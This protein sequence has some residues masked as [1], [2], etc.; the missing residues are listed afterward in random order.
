MKIAKDDSRLPRVRRSALDT[1]IEF[2]KQDLDTTDLR[3]LLKDVYTGAV[4]DPDDELLGTL[5]KAL[6]TKVLSVSDLLNYLRTP[7]ELS[8]YGKYVSFWIRYFPE[9]STNEQLAEF[10]STIIER[11]DQFPVLHNTESQVADH[12]R[13]TFF[14]QGKLLARL[15]A[16][17]LETVQGSVFSVVPAERLFNWLEVVLDEIPHPSLE[18]RAIES[19]LDSHPDEYKEMIRT[20]MHRSAESTN[21]LRCMYKI[22]D[23]FR[24]VARPPGFA[25][26][27]LEQAV[28]STDD[29]IKEYLICRVAR[30]VYHPRRDEGLSREVVEEHLA[31]DR[32]A[33]DMFTEKLGHLEH[34]DRQQQEIQQK[35]GEKYDAEKLS[36]WQQWHDVVRRHRPALRENKCVPEILHK[37]A[38]IYFGTYFDVEGNTPEERLRCVF[39]EDD[40]LIETV[41]DG[42]RGSVERTDVPE[43]ENMLHLFT[44]NQEHRMTLP[45]LAGLEIVGGP[46]GER[47]IHQA[48]AAHYISTGARHDDQPPAWYDPVLESHTVVAADVLVRLVRAGIRKGSSVAFGVDRLRDSDELARLASMSLLKTFPARCSAQQLHALEILL[49]A[50]LR[51]REAA[52]ILELTDRKLAH[53]S[54]NTSQRVYWLFTGVLASGSAESCRERLREHVSGNERRARCLTGFVVRLADFIYP[55]C[56]RNLDTSALQLLIE[57]M[58][59]SYAPVEPAAFDPRSRLISGF[60]DKLAILPSSEAAQALESLTDDDALRSWK[61]YLVHAM[62][63]QNTLRREAGFS[64]SGVEQVLKTLDNNQPANVADLAALTFGFFTEIARNIG[65][66]NTNDWRQYWNWD[67]KSHR[68]RSK[69]M[70]EDHCRD[71]LLSDL[72]S[73]IRP[74]GIDAAPEGRYVDEK[75]SDIRVSY[76]GFNVPVEIKKSNHLDLWSAIQEQLIAKYTRDPGAGGYGIYLVFWFGKEHCQPPES[77]SRPGSAAELEKRLRDTLSP[78]EA[79]VIEICVIDVAAPPERRQDI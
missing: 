65:D 31:G 64:H 30:S 20:G 72:Q 57:I 53:R 63:R 12:D 24:D 34:T 32:A 19:W 9:N 47:Q 42:L 26:W 39:G 15:L 36:R 74:L 66:G 6:Y 49:G 16:R 2:R 76:G 10:L 46:A 44:E 58:G 54:M 38:R 67:Q 71:R 23:R 73:R 28:S 7:K 62:D 33:L 35:I 75:R 69:P 51:L 37:L 60:I 1:F 79:R 13:I 27:C 59:N 43:A 61:L 56:I 8:L 68:Q 40:D 25:L 3:V 52:E 17:F 14:N 48:L 18:K 70:H 45:F 21:F 77:G 29:R 55:E 22:E 78:E 11:F 4:S 41:L 5:L 50:A